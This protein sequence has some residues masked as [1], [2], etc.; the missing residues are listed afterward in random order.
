MRVT[1][2]R[3]SLAALLLAASGSGVPR[4][5]DEGRVRFY[6]PAHKLFEAEART[7]CLPGD[8]RCSDQATAFDGGGGD[9]PLCF[10]KACP[11]Y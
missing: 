9:P 11:G 1:M 2:I 10:P 4:A 7:V 3:L 6:P 5:N 8:P